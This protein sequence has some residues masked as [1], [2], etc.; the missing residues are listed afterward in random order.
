ANVNELI[1]TPSGWLAAAAD[2]VWQQ[3]PS[4]WTRVFQP[5][6]WMLDGAGC[7]A[8]AR[9]VVDPRVAGR[10]LSIVPTR[11]V[12]PCPLPFILYGDGSEVFLSGDDGATWRGIGPF[13][14]GLT[15][16]AQAQAGAFT[17]SNIVIGTGFQ[18][19]WRSAD[20]GASWTN[21]RGMSSVLRGKLWQPKAPVP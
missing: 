10:S 13:A 3:K 2:G 15:N 6:S 7:K 19:A 17:A 14:A 16:I 9:V 20:G 21:A 4:G 1:P 11:G 8:V 18:N 12:D 5:T